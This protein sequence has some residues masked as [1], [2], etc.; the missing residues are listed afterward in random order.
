MVPRIFER[1]KAN[2]QQNP[3][4]FIVIDGDK[5]KS[6]NDTYGHQTG[7]AMLKA[8]S[9]ILRQCVRVHDSLQQLT[10]KGDCLVRY[11]GEE[12]VV[13]LEGTD[14]KQA[15]QVAERIRTSIES[16]TDWPGGIPKW[17]VSLG[18]AAFPNDG[19]NI[20]ELFEKADIA[21]YYVKEELGRN[22]SCLASSVP[23]SFAGKK[24]VAMI[25]GELGVFDPITTIQNFANSMKT[26][27]L[28]VTQKDGKQFWMSFASGKPMQARLG[29]FG[30]N[31]AIT[32]YLVTFDDGE[33]KFQ[34]VPDAN[35]L[36]KHDD[37]Y[38]ITKGLDRSLMDGALA[39]DN[40][41]AARV[42][43]SDTEIIISPIDQITFNEKWNSLGSLPD[44][45]TPDEFNSMAEIVKL[46]DGKRSLEKIFKQLDTIP[47]H[48]VYRGAFWLI[49][50]GLV[51]V[52]TPQGIKS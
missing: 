33:F 2:P 18:I 14:A 24:K 42:V 3:I 41:E 19:R 35:K 15:M 28:T 39:Q 7:D 12:F 38:N 8:L 40:F 26:G 32:E 29:K 48:S 13:V 17:T 34:E 36:P 16:K 47:T 31:I 20:A 27:M 46:A 51:E 37:I 6:I 23:K 50:Q 10:D 11:G 43:V 52:L 4:S 21:L 30:G 5:F 25:Q 22:K 9:D 1:A 45:P 44:P 49:Q